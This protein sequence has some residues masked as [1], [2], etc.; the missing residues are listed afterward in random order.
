MEAVLSRL[1][2]DAHFKY[3]PD[4]THFDVYVVGQDRMG[5]F[6]DIGQQ[7]WETARPGQKWKQAAAK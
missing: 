2:A 3:L 7:M 4:R 6:D 1:G 5:L